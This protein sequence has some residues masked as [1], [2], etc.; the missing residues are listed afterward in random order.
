[1]T[2]AI[3]ADT[4]FAHP[5]ARVWA[6]LTD[7]AKLSRWLMPTDFR[8]ELGAT[9]TLDAG[10][11]GKIQCEV[12]ELVPESTLKIS[13]KAQMLDTTVT[14]RL[15]AEGAG[16]RL[17]LEH[18]GFDLANPMHQF[19]YNGMKGGWSG[20]IPERLAAILAE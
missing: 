1:M 19:A 10:Q 14:W 15:V 5:P 6:A 16:T 12:L 13:W 4:F 3:V 18:A 2:T 9:F 8:A 11:W 7:P 17:H 20:N